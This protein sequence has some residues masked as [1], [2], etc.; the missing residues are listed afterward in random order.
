MPDGNIEY[1]GRIDAQVKI[2]GYRIELGEVETQLLKLEA[3]QE[4]GHRA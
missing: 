1:K 4:C 2:R 3:V